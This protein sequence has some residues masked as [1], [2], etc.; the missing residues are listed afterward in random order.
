M[1]APTTKL[2]FSEAKLL[3]DYGFSTYSFQ[4]IATK[5]AVAQNVEISKGTRK[6]CKS[7]V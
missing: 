3:L 7:C 1:R 4:K 2:R 6:K 5:G